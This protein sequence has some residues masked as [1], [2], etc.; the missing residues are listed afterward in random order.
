MTDPFSFFDFTEDEAREALA[1]V[2]DKTKVRGKICICGHPMGRHSIT[3]G[4]TSCTAGKQT[5]PCK[6]A[7]AVIEVDN[8]RIFLRRT[9]GGGAL[10]A[11]TLGMTAALEAGQQVDWVIDVACDRCGNSGLVSPT[12]V[13]ENGVIMNKATGYNVLLCRDCREA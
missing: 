9:T 2:S 10:H 11:L 4:L 1:V 8:A 6:R 12:P 13:T 3:S 5:C 7:R